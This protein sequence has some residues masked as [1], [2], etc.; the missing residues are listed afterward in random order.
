[1]PKYRVHVFPIVRV[2]VEVEAED[3]EK[4]AKK[5]VEETDFERLLHDEFADDF[6]DAV[7]V[8]PLDEDGEID[9]EHSAWLNPWEKGET[10]DEAVDKGSGGEVQ[11][12]R[13]PE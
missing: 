3:R 1:M 13:Q 4:A 12:D 6:D 8:D 7:L 2:S 10:K 9:Y 11:E 5:A